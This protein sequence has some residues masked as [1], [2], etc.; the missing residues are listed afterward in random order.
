MSAPRSRGRR[1]YGVMNVL[2][3]TTIMFWGRSG[4]RRE[5]G[6]RGTI[7]HSGM[8]VEASNTVRTSVQFA[9]RVPSLC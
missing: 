5:R 1:K 4:R 2:S 7:R 9:Y 3:I 6:T 8:T